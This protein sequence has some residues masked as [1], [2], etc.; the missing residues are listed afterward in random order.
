MGYAGSRRAGGR[1][2]RP[3]AGVLLVV[4]VCALVLAEGRMLTGGRAGSREPVL[5]LA[6]PVAA[7]QVITAADLRV[8]DVA[9]AGPVSLVRP[10][11]WPRWRAAQRRLAC[12]R[13]ACWLPA[14]SARR[15]RPGARRGWA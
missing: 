5:A 4:A 1:R 12:R 2:V 13:A 14:T 11:G 7:G 6:R 15:P 9:A 10:G 3:V 8:V